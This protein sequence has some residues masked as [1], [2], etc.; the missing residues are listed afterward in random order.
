MTE[1]ND[2]LA[3]YGLWRLHVKHELQEKISVLDL[4]IQELQNLGDLYVRFLQIDNDEPTK[5][6]DVALLDELLQA[7]AHS[8]ISHRSAIATVAETIKGSDSG[9]TGD[10]DF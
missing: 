5:P 1:G 2:L 10:W 9:E 7:F 8:V 6:A 4:A 3:L